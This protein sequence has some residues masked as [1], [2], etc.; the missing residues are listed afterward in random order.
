MAGTLKSLCPIRCLKEKRGNPDVPELI[1]DPLSQY[2][3][4][5]IHACAP[6]TFAV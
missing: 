6:D 4:E 2:S 3:L 5:S 1:R